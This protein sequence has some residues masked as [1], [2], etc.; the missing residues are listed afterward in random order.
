LCFF[1]DSTKSLSGATSGLARQTLISAAHRFSRTL[2]V[3]AALFRC[4]KRKKAGDR[5]YL[6]FIADGHVISIL[7]NQSQPLVRLTEDVVGVAMDTS[8]GSCLASAAL[9]ADI[10]KRVTA[11]HQPIA[12]LTKDKHAA[13]ARFSNELASAPEVHMAGRI[14]TKSGNL[15]WAA[16]MIYFS[17]YTNEVSTTDPGVPA[18]AAGDAAAG[19]D[20]DGSDENEPAV[21]QAVGAGRGG[22]AAAAAVIGGSGG[23]AAARSRGP[24]YISKHVPGAIGVGLGATVERERWRVV[25]RFVLTFLDHPVVRAFAGLPRNRIKRPAYKIFMGVPLAEWR[26]YAATVEMVGLVW[27]FLQLE[28]MSEVDDPLMTRAIG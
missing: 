4:S 11:E 2:I 1:L 5:P 20:G 16:G 17:F 27:P 12:R 18:T 26:P 3:P 19:N 15:A 9:R 10:C 21:A 22:Q 23:A 14:C 7:H 24:F 13:L 25:R 28:G 6:A 8:H